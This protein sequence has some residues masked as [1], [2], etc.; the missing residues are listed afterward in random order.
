MVQN[1]LALSYTDGIHAFV[2][3]VHLSDHMALCIGSWCPAHEINTVLSR[4][5]ETVSKESSRHVKLVVNLPRRS[6]AN[7]RC[8]LFK[9][10]EHLISHLIPHLIHSREHHHA[11][12]CCTHRRGGGQH[13]ILKTRHNMHRCTTAGR[14][15]QQS[16]GWVTNSAARGAC[17]AIFHSV[18]VVGATSARVVSDCS[19]LPHHLDKD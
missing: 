7:R 11:R 15:R 10:L 13:G 18:V 17:L 5:H 3:S 4:G 9:T 19:C 12:E 2:D 6:C 14:P 8:E 1:H 16:T